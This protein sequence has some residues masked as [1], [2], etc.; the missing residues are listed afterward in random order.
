MQIISASQRSCTL[1]GL[2]FL[3]SCFSLKFT[4]SSLVE[5][6]DTETHCAE[7]ELVPART[8]VQKLLKLATRIMQENLSERVK[9]NSILGKVTLRKFVEA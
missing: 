7:R 6:S 9:S 1:A 2:S 5:K 4:T 3:S 8:A